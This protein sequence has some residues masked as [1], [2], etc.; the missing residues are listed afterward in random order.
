MNTLLEKVETYWTRRSSDYCRVNE[1]E[2]N[3]F[4]HKA[5]TDI[6]NEY[7]PRIPGEPLRVL[8]AGTGPGF[9]ALIMANCGH[10][11]T[12]VDYTEAMLE[13]ARMNAEKYNRLIS[14]KRMDAQ[15]MDF[16]DN[17][18]DLILTR[19]LIWNLGQPEKAYREFYR[20][21]SPGGRLLNFDANWYLH[22][23][24]PVKRQAYEQDRLNAQKHKCPDH[25]TCTDTK[26]ME[27]IA[28]D[29]PLSRIHRPEWDAGTLAK[30]GFKKIMIELDIKDRVWDWEEK[31]NYDSTPLFM[32]C[33]EK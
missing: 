30:T 28:A 7:A 26:T 14:F 11:V 16:E 1:E 32:V 25:Y 23:H 18:F 21:L 4:K 3:S 9:F 33:A 10:R 15:D 29:L 31:I 2:L 22:I 27:N 17:A 5:W 12:A 19:N 20:V 13:K 8:D 24:D 6:I